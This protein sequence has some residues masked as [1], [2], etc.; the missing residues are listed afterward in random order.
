M[1]FLHVRLEQLYNFPFDLLNTNLC[2]ICRFIDARA[3]RNCCACLYTN[4][5]PFDRTDIQAFKARH[6]LRGIVAF[7]SK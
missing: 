5:V 1:A 4:E 7:I 3:R 2:L 6:Q